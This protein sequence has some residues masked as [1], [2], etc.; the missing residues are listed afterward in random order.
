MVSIEIQPTVIDQQSFLPITPVL[1]KLSSYMIQ[2]I[3]R[4]RDRDGVAAV[5]GNELI[6]AFEEHNRRQFGGRSLTVKPT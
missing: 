3:P 6:T 2:A 4:L 1:V 5:L